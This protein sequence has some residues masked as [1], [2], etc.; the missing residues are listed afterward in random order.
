MRFE[1]SSRNSWILFGLGLFFCSIYL[2][3]FSK[4]ALADGTSGVNLGVDGDGVGLSFVSVSDSRVAFSYL[5]EKTRQLKYRERDSAGRFSTAVI[6]TLG[7]IPKTQV[8][9]ELSVVSKTALAFLSGEPHVFYFV[10]EN[11]QLRHAYRQGGTW[12]VEVVDGSSRAGGSPS[13]I[14]C[15]NKLCVAYYD[16]GNK[17]LRFAKGNTGSW[18]IATLDSAGAVGAM[19][20]IALAPGGKAV[21]AYFDSTNLKLKLARES[22]SG[23]WTTEIIPEYGVDFGIYPSVSVG[24]DGSIHISSSRYKSDNTSQDLGVFY[25]KRSPVGAWDIALVSDSYAGGPTCL[26][27]KGSEVELAFRKLQVS[28]MH[29]NATALGLAKLDAS[30]FW[31]FRFFSVQSNTKG[32]IDLYDQIGCF[33]NSRGENAIAI[34]V[35]GNVRSGVAASNALRYLSRLSPSDSGTSNFYFG[36][37]TPTDQEDTDGDGL[38]DEAERRAGTDPN[39]PDSDG[40]GVSDGQEVSDGSSPLDPGSVQPR[41]ATSICVEWNGFLGGM[42]NILEHTNLS[43]LPLTVQTTLYG[44][45]GDPLGTQIFGI[46][47]GAQFDALVHDFDG[48]FRDSIGMVC[49][50]HNGQPGDLD[51]RMVYYKLNQGGASNKH[52]EFAFAMPF[53][54]GIKGRQYVPYNT[55]QPSLAPGDAANWVANW[56]QLTNLS[57]N[58]QNGTLS[59]YA[60]DGSLLSA[61]RLN[62]SPRARRDIS[63]HQVGASRVGLVEWVPDDKNA[64]FQLR[65]VRYLYDNPFGFNTFATAFQLEG[66]R[67]SGESLVTPMDAREGSV[68]IEISNTSESVNHVEVDITSDSGD[69]LFSGALALGPRA[70]FHLIADE[71][72]GGRMGLARVKGNLPSSVTAVA[73]HYIRSADGGVRYMYGIPGR[74]ALRTVLRGSYNTYLGQES[75]LLISNPNDSTQSANISLTRSDGTSVLLEQPVL[76]PANGVVVVSLNQFEAADNYGVLTLQSEQGRN[77][78]GVVVRTRPGEYGI[79]TP[80]R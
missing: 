2:S 44:I 49:S 24:S 34:H 23:S 67:G 7:S 35:R 19:N 42:F 53:L 16:K 72:I 71:F 31:Q 46:A 3:V 66:G 60:F 40:D 32:N 43:S 62:I 33:K 14:P 27:L 51:G 59:L 4:W 73:M 61:Q 17:D 12:K 69:L 70:S 79:P 6:E 29:G 56:I 36:S 64:G 20:S 38:S 45:G 1:V 74:E 22:S 18:N 58:S 57:S 39:N 52:F 25:A 10:N 13:A 63:G 78:L 75:S 9:S 68:V 65:N 80:V 76:V 37:Y 30:G 47:P 55:Y 15:G 21:V 48:W 26:M 50:A 28:S 8:S 77:L 5:N 11:S 54:N 41:L